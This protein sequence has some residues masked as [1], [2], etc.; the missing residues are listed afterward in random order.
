MKLT[1]KLL[2]QSICTSALA[3]VL[4]A[5]I[6][7]SM[8]R[9]N[10]SSYEQVQHLL[11][12]QQ[13][14][15]ELHNAG[16]VL[17][18]TSTIRTETS[19]ADLRTYLDQSESSF[20]Q[21]LSS[22]EGQ[23]A[24]YLEAG[25]EKYDEWQSD[26]TSLLTN[27]NEME[28]LRL[29]SRVEG[30]LNDVYMANAY[31]TA[32]YED[33]QLALQN[34]ITFVIVV[35]LI[36]VLLLIV[37]TNYISR[38]TS[39]SIADPLLALASRTNQIAAGDLTVEPIGKAGSFEIKQMNDAFGQM[40]EQLKGLIGSIEKASNEVAVMSQ[41][42]D[43]DN[44]NLQS[45]H[46]NIAASVGEIT[47]GSQ[48][49]S[50]DLQQTVELIEQMDKQGKANSVFATETVELGKLASGAAMRGR[51]TVVNQQQLTI[52]NNE[53]RELM[54][55]SLRDF[56]QYSHQIEQMVASVSSVAEQT[57]LLA[58]NAAIEA[59]RAGEAGKGFAVVADEIRKLADESK[60]SADAI[61]RSVGAIRQGTMNLSEAVQFGNELA[62]AEAASMES[63]ET[64]FVE[65]EDKFQAIS[66][67]LQQ[68]Q[69]GN[70]Q[71]ERLGG[72][73]LSRVAQINSTLQENTA[74]TDIVH[75]STNEQY[76]AYEQLAVTV[77]ELER[78]TNDLQEAVAVFQTEAAES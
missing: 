15:S 30:L 73:V 62:K 22:S 11:Q 65:I 49:I 14:D 44:H 74:K 53:S 27:V 59:A 66:G 2:W 47:S 45:L 37:V 64:S 56:T 61:Y 8:I 77:G 78:V 68:I 69:S 34:Q 46:N 33:E 70:V 25:K 20:E 41:E 3:F 23:S 63:M 5:F 75:H 43:K 55:A 32:A 7:M 31:S 52:K 19:A 71:S 54:E 18:N 48:R 24:V 72:D 6:I 39:K 50:A 12:L 16:Q 26:V 58:L 51:E 10:A 28:A 35:S 29:S 60:V 57:N 67:R 13:L 36:G 4:I 38:R 9:I 17:R 42:I 1:R 76:E 40:T 21:L